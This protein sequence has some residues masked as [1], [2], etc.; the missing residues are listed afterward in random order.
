MYIS[1]NDVFLLS[2]SKKGSI[3]FKT[4]FTFSMNYLKDNE[5]NLIVFSMI[6]PH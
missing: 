4:Y 6:I 2:E 3:S 1:F 5:A